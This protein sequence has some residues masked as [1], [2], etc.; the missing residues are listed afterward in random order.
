M[1]YETFA[2]EQLVRLADNS[3]TD[4]QIADAFTAIKSD[5]TIKQLAG[6]YLA[7]SSERAPLNLERLNTALHN[8]FLSE[9]IF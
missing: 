7:G 9:V 3:L 4:K 8:K 1:I 6:M 2:H 5:S